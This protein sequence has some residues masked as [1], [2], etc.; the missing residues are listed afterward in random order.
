MGLFYKNDGGRPLLIPIDKM[1]DID[2][3]E[4]DDPTMAISVT[5][6]EPGGA[7]WTIEVAEG[8]IIRK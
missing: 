7:W 8:D 5:A 4:T 1:F 2:G 6:H 3:D